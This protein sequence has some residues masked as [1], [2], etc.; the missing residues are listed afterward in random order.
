VDPEQIELT[1]TGDMLTLKGERAADEVPEEARAHRRE[2]W[3]G[4]FTR[5]LSIPSGFDTQ[6]LSASCRDG[7]LTVRL[8]RQEAAKPRQI[9]VR[10]R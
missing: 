4:S 10:R 1:A 6:Q 7:L 8:G 9:E 5:S 2:R 3:S